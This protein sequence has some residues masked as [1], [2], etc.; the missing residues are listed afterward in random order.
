MGKEGQNWAMDGNRHMKI[1]AVHLLTNPETER[2][3]RSIA[4]VSA[5]AQFG[6][7]Y[8]PIINAPYDGEIPPARECNDRGFDLTPA[9]YG[10]FMAHKGALDHLTPDLSALVVCEC[11]CVFVEEPERIA[12]R[13]KRMVT[14]CYEGNIEIAT[15]GYRHNGKTLE[16][17]GDDVIVI[18]QLIE[19]HCLIIPQHARERIKALFDLPWDAADFV[20]TVYGYDRSNLRIGT[21]AD[22]ALAVQATGMSLIDNRV[23]TTEDFVRAVRY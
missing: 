9:H 22:R 12:K 10:C 21:F 14:A 19:T 13:I 23:K 2:E 11:D 4:E 6:L 18:S 3:R 1:R 7:E 17:I 20:F 8:L 16:K 15:L 5:L